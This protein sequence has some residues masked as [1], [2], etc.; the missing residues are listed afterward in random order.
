MKKNSK[1]LLM[2]LILFASSIF[3]PIFVNADGHSLPNSYDPQEVAVFINGHINILEQ[4]TYL[5]N[6]DK[7]YLPLKLLNSLKGV[8][9]DTNNGITV[10]SSKGK[11]NINKTNSVI[12]KN[13]TYITFEKLLQITGY[14]G[15]YVGEYTTVYL[16]DN[17]GHYQETVKI[18]NNLKTVPDS[19]RWY[20]GSKVYLYQ[21]NQF[22]WVINMSSSGLITDVEI[23]L[24]NSKIVHETIFENVPSTFCHI[25]QY[26]L[27]TKEAF[28]NEYV[29]ANKKALPS[30]T[31]L[32]NI[33]RIKILSLSIKDG[34]AVIQARRASNQKV[35]FK[36]PING[37]PNG[38]IYDHFYTQDPKKE[39]PNW[40]DR[41]W[42]LIAQQK[43]AIGM[44]PD[45]VL[46]S[47]GGP[48]DINTYTSSYSSFEQWV[49][50]NTY[51]HFYN[52]RLDSWATY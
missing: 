25:L 28:K 34:N 35:T 51:L 9:L 40:T 11:F 52:G 23:Q 17:Y 22:G 19:V 1:Y 2:L 38:V 26:N 12:Y 33:E 39:H 21:T 50:G 45:Q 15:K 6:D 4:K 49:Y 48:N 32:Y 27:F 30:S 10:A 46:M 37:Y 43:I 47:W 5:A 42:N 18:I 31:P 8:S 13:S 14:S 16:W 44:T 20:M 24:V 3:R 7:V 41:I 36:I 29:W